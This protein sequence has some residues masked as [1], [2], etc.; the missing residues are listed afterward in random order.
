MARI[1]RKPNGKWLIETSWYDGNGKRRYKSKGGFATKQAARQYAAELD[2]KKYQGEI[3]DDD[4]SFAEYFMM[5]FETY[6][7]NSVALTTKKRYLNDY[8]F[9][10]DYF[11]NRKLSSITRFQYQTFLNAF[12]KNHAPSTVRK[13]NGVVR[14]CVK[15][16]IVDNLINKDFTIGVKLGGDESRSLHVEYLN[17]AE[18]NTLVKYLKNGRQP[19]YTSRYMILTA[20]YTGMRLGEIMA[21][22]WHDVNFNFKTI[23]INKSWNYVGG[24]GFKKTKTPSSI[25]TIRI[26]D[27]LLR[28][29]AELKD[30]HQDMVFMNANNQIPSSNAVNTL[31]RKS[32]AACDMSKQDF[33][34]HSL[35]HSHVAYLLANGIPLYAISKRLGHSNTTITANKY[36]YLIDEFKARSDEMIENSLNKIDD[37]NQ[38]GG[39][40]AD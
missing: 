26:N 8:K 40:T 4:P 1:V 5:W 16:A 28:L 21:L 30:N 14:E 39:L 23:T 19:R 10:A 33:H 32:L 34:F 13:F 18:I 27:S 9:I 36:A 37:K 15:N 6:K 22:T 11:R 20:I 38:V 12:G 3:T 29:L 2:S 24:G 35:R 7:E 31:L 25:R 17:I